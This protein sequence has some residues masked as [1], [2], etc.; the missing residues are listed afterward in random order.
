[1]ALFGEKLM[2]ADNGVYIVKNTSEATKNFAA[3]YVLEDTV[4][5]SLKV[6]GADAKSTYIA[7]TGTALKAGAL[8][9]PTSGIAYF[10]GITLT[11]GS[12]ALILA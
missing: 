5:S 9:R 1:M 2:S 11:S 7:A 3:V 6:D 12:V 10:S 4:I 8:I